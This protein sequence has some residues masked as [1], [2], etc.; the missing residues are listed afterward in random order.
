MKFPKGSQ[1]RIWSGAHWS[2]EA[3]EVVDYN[4][5]TNTYQ[6]QFKDDSRASGVRE[7]HIDWHSDIWMMR[8]LNN[9]VML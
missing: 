6:I 7:F 8:H 5:D 9:L 4:A 1:V 2:E 3:S